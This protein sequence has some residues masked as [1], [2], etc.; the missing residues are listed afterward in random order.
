MRKSF[1]AFLFLALCLLLLVG[2][3]GSARMS[4][5]QATPMPTAS[6]S[7]PAPSPQ[8]SN[9]PVPPTDS[10]VQPSPIAEP[11]YINSFY[12]SDANS[13]LIELEHRIVTFRSSDIVVPGYAS[14][15][16]TTKL[17][18]R[19]SPVRA[20][21]TAQ[22]VVRGRAPIDP[23]TRFE[24]RKLKG[25]KDHREFVM[26]QN[27]GTLLG[28]SGTSNPERDDVAIRFEEYG[29]NSYRITP[30][31]PLDHGEY[32]LAVRGSISELY[33]FGVDR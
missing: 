13:R 2:A 26:A 22:F 29:A 15:K 9:E 33:C 3:S 27:Y 14:F 18:P 6:S 1:V 25:S 12:A 7:V 24:L 4:G 5:G 30:V 17:K 31:T 20:A 19:R 23:S 32:A 21:V 8:A 28:H 10:A 16:D 11:K